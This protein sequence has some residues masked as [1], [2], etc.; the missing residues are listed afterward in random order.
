MIAL[1]ELV[2]YTSN[3]SPVVPLVLLL[4]LKKK[5]TKT[6]HILTAIIGLSFCSDA[7]SFFMAKKH[8][9]TSAFYN[10]YF[11]IQFFLLSYLYRQQVKNKKRIVATIIIFLAFFIINT[12]FLQPFTV[13]QSWLR[14]AGGIICIAYSVGFFREMM[15][16]DKA[17]GYWGDNPPID[18]FYH[19]PFW[20]NAGIFYYFSFNLFLFA[21]DNFIF[22]HMSMQEIKVF[23]GFHNF[24]NIIKNLLFTFAVISFKKGN[25]SPL[26]Y[27]KD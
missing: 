15:R 22:S 4:T 25:R 19:Y 17:E 10:T 3:L 16:A 21:M 12:L 26:I 24:N 7:I 13:Y 9:D 1:T 6:I 5:R 23:L 2:R 8:I 11:V 27:Y 18:P 14:L 20:I